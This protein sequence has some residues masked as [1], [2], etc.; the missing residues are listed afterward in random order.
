MERVRRNESLSKEQFHDSLRQWLAS[1]AE[2]QIGQQA[3][4]GRTPWVHVRDGSRI[5]ALNADTSRKAVAH[6]LS[7]V[8]L[9]GDDLEWQI[10]PTQ[11]G[12]MTAV[13]Y[14]P[15]AER[16]KPFYLYARS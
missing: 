2:G 3:G 8:D 14:G 10:A 12:N 9:H 5:F 1:P 11:R 7:L 16:H 6:Y 4:Q 15:A 13:V